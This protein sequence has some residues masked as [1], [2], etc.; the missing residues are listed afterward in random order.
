MTCPYVTKLVAAAEEV[1]GAHNGRP[2]ARRP[3]ASW[4][5]GAATPCGVWAT[6]WPPPTPAGSSCCTCPARPGPDVT[7]RPCRRPRA[8]GRL[9][10]GPPARR[11]GR[12]G[13][14]AAARRTAHSRL[15]PSRPARR[16]VRGQRTAEQRLS[17][18]P[19][20]QVGRSRVGPGVLHLARPLEAARSRRARSPGA[21]RELGPAD[22]QALA[23][24]VLATGMCPRRSTAD[25][26]AHLERRLDETKPT[27]II[28]ARQSFC[29]PGA[30]DAL[31][32]RP[33]WPSEREPALPGDRGGLPLRRQRPAARQ[34]RG[35]PGSPAHGRR[36]AERPTTCSRRL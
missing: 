19:H 7:A 14:A 1:L 2:R 12:P 31:L 23:A 17:A 36:P 26:R 11:R 33:T 10:A 22:Y 29:D 30:Y 18:R 24:R 8:P 3:T 32:R 15:R 25:R 13:G 9:A 16:R 21:S 34:G 5:P 27:S 6:C 35:L 20:R 4:C 28:Y